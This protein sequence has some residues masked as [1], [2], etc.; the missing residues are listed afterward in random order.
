MRWIYINFALTI[1]NDFVVWNNSFSFQDF[2]N[3]LS[4]VSRGSVEEKL[5]WVFGLYDLNG[6]GLITKTEMTDV[7]TSIYEMLGKATQ[8]LVEDNSAKEHVDK[9]FH[10]TSFCLILWVLS[11]SHALICTR[12]S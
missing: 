8:P 10:V 5:Q 12:H 9:I 4:K 2:L 11:D 1:L 3:I 7:V 6:D